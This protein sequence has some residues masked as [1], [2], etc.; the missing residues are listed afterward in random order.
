MYGRLF[1]NCTI[2]YR[3][4]PLCRSLWSLQCLYSSSSWLFSCGTYTSNLH[5]QKGET[6]RLGGFWMCVSVCLCVCFARHFYVFKAYTKN[7]ECFSHHWLHEQQCSSS[8]KER[9]HIP[10]L[11]IV[12]YGECRG[13]SSTQY[14]PTAQQFNAIHIEAKIH[15]HPNTMSQLLPSAFSLFLQRFFLV[16]SFLNHNN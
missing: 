13:C 4:R 11:N 14:Y 3:C 15:T 1:K 5:R 10:C 8:D 16:S 12:L 2:S 9:V 7:D 6:F